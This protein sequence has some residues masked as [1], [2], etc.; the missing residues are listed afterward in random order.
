MQLFSLPRFY[1]RAQ[2]RRNNFC[3][4]SSY[5]L[6]YVY[7]IK[8]SPLIRNAKYG[9]DPGRLNI[10]LSSKHDERIIISL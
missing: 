3:E 9:L 10:A 8:E 5:E 2:Q 7:R 1:L 4:V 6:F